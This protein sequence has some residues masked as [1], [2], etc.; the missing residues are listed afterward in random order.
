MQMEVN[1]LQET[2]ICMVLA[3][4]LYSGKYV[5]QILKKASNFIDVAFK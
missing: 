2:Y 4:L 1:T 3:E 5:K